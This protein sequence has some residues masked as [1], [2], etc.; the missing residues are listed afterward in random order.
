MHSQKE[1]DMKKYIVTSGSSFP[2]ELM[3]TA[4][5]AEKGYHSG[6]CSMD[7]IDLMDE[8][9][10]KSQTDRISDDVLNKWWDEL[11]LDGLKEKLDDSRETKLEWLIFECCALVADGCYTE[12]EE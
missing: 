1:K 4:E 12:V 6:E 3:L 10:I 5:Q 8:E 11:F 7:V 9:S 2:I